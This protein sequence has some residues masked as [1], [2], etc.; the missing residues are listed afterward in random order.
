MA[1]EW[2]EVLKG[3]HRFPVSGFAEYVVQP[4]VGAHGTPAIGVGT[5]EKHRRDGGKARGGCG[6]VGDCLGRQVGCL[7]WRRDGIQRIGSR[8]EG[9]V[10][11][12]WLVLRRDFG[13]EV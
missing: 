9:M 11:E 1:G 6:G 2:E 5:R 13:A 8:R 12:V 4:V 7:L 10:Q 3:T